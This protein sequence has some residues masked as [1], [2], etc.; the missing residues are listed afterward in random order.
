M[1]RIKVALCED[2]GGVR[3]LLAQSLRLAFAQEGLDADVAR[4]STGDALLEAVGRGIAYDAFFLDI[5]MPGTNGIECCRTIRAGRPDAVVVFVSNKE[6]LVFQSFEVQPFRFMRKSHY[7]EE[8]GRVVAAVARELERARGH[9]VVLSEASTGRSWRMD[10]N[11]L[12][13]VEVRN[14][15]CCLH[16]VRGDL[17]IRCRLQDVESALQG[18]PFLKPHRSYLVN[19]RHVSC[20]GRDAVQMD[21]GMQIPLSRNRAAETTAQF[22]RLVQEEL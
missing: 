21:D 20:V 15:T 1:R 17:E 7:V 19:A 2:E 8:Q 9:V 11:D 12:L 18:Q 10:V 6:E 14:K 4:F 3:E 5:E 13:V 22:M 16:T